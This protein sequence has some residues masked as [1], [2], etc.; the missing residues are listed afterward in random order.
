[1]KEN[2]QHNADRFIGFADIYDNAR[3][4]CPEK[5]KQI[6]LKYLGRTPSLVVDLG[7]GTGLSTKVWSE[8]SKE[9]IGI[10]PSTDMIQ[11]AREKSAGLD[12]V[13]F[14]SKF[15]DNTGLDD[16]CADIITCAQSFHWMDPETT[17]IEVSRI[18]KK[19]G[20]F[21]IYDC[22][23]PPV[24]NLEAELEYNK[25][26][27]QVKKIE[28]THL[29]LKERFTRWNKDRH[30][31]NIK[32]SGYFR[33]VREIV[34]SNSEICNA[35]RF[36]AIALSQGGLQAIMK[37][38]IE[39]ITPFLLSFKEKILSVFGNDEFKIDFCY[40]MRIGVK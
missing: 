35:Q 40:R 2:L 4:K 23:W 12:N 32:N 9:V 29:D 27:E 5:V 15:S 34:F 6:I 38:N 31:S 30:L 17:L 10:E 14:K 26:F 24:C 3:P 11:I 37:A 33:Y 1:M 39:E 28:S 25:L 13:I 18:L 16:D 21:A 36:I 8:V 22:D 20:V 19:G 7:C